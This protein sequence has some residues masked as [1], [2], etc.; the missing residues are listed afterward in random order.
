MFDVI[1]V[2]SDLASGR[3]VA[4][5]SMMPSAGPRLVIRDDLDLELA[6]ASS[7]SL[8][9][10]WHSSMIRTSGNRPRL[11]FARQLRA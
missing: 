9:A 8:N 4:R 1:P 6:A 2:G 5:I 7:G 3:W 10:S 11:R